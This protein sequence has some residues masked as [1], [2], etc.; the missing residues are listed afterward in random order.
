MTDC[1]IKYGDI[2]TRAK[3]FE[4]AAGRDLAIAKC[5][6][7]PHK[8]R[9]NDLH[10]ESADYQQ[11]A[12]LLDSWWRLADSDGK[13]ADWVI[14]NPPFNQQQPIIQNAYE[15]ARVGWPCYCGSQRMKWW[16]GKRRKLGRIGGPITPNP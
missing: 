16:W 4:P 8:V 5:F 10:E 15:F 6:S 7:H 11:D 12:T 13:V 14:S 2:D 3:I 9:T 1:L